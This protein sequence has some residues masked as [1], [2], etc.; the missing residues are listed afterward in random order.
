M[1]ASVSL[2]G[3]VRPS[4]ALAVFRDTHRG[5]DNFF[6]AVW[7]FIDLAAGTEEAVAATSAQGLFCMPLAAAVAKD[8]SHLFVPR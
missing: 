3:L 6:L 5:H 7:A 8:G 4:S 2:L 1:K